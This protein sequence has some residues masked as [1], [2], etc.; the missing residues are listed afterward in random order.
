MKN[1]TLFLICL[2][3]SAAITA[4]EKVKQAEIGLIFNNTS[5]FGL[6]FKVGSNKFKWRFNTLLINGRNDKLTLDSTNTETEAKQSGFELTV[7]NQFQ[8]PITENFEFV[9]GYDLFFKASKTSYDDGAEATMIVQKSRSPG[10]NLVFGFNYIAKEHLVLGAEILPFFCWEK[11]ITERDYHHNN[12][13]PVP[14]SESKSINYGL[15]NT[16]AR[17]TLA[18]RF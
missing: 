3:V 16:S 14:I 15:S 11:N 10:I 9:F 2:I 6:G 8:K 5:N 7:G 18:Y 17:L 13:S 4:Q 12:V 1:L